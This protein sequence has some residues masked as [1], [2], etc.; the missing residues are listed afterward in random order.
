MS[1]QLF[2][3]VLEGFGLWLL[4]AVLIAG[5]WHRIAKAQAKQPEFPIQRLRQHLHIVKLA[6]N[7]HATL[8]EPEDELEWLRR[9][10]T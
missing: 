3:R 2:G 10:R 9:T 8:I 4:L 5:C 6:P 1:I 7:D